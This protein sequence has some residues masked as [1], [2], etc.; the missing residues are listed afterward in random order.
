[1]YVLSPSLSA[2]GYW[3]LKTHIH[4]CET[5]ESIKVGA[6][7]SSLLFS[8]VLFPLLFFSFFLFTSEFYVYTLFPF[9]HFIKFT[10]FHDLSLSHVHICRQLNRAKHSW[11]LQHR[12]FFSHQFIWPTFL[13]EDRHTT[14]T[15]THYLQRTCECI[16]NVII[17]FTR[18]NK[19]EHDKWHDVIEMSNNAPRMMINRF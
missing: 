3:N 8:L 16:S 2:L 14:D 18:K 1:M 15:R 12:S 17:N 19:Y 4:E 9:F 6:S 13:I 5:D 10:L 7:Y 11:A